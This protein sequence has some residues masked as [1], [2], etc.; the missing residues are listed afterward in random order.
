MRDRP[1]SLIK[2]TAEWVVGVKRERRSE[3]MK[4]KM[5]V[6][7]KIFVLKNLPVRSDKNE[8]SMRQ[9]N[10]KREKRWASGGGCLK[11]A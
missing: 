7:G 11:E 8:N 4:K 5:L 9:R 3:T 1:N 6:S 2:S 10:E